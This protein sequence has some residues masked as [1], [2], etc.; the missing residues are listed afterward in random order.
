MSLATVTH[1]T[2]TLRESLS[3]DIALVRLLARVSELVHP[4]CR[5]PRE[6]FRTQLALVGPFA[7]VRT[8]VYPQ[9]VY[10]REFLA[11]LGAQERLRVQAR[12]IA[13]AELRGEV[14]VTK[15]APV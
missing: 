11:A 1:H 6:I 5:G 3:A 15:V 7:G 12:V 9:R 2:A 10:R 8:F 13:K 4:E 14:L